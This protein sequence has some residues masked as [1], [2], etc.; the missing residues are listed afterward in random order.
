MARDG[1]SSSPHPETGRI[2]GR[3]GPVG[4]KMPVRDK[5][6]YEKIEQAIWDVEIGLDCLYCLDGGESDEVAEEAGNLL[7][8]ATHLR[9]RI[10]RCLGERPAGR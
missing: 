4:G 10:I 2:L 9:R 7:E 5:A 1:A 8:E 3:A 6:R